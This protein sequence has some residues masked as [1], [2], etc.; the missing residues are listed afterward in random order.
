MNLT[1]HGKLKDT[2]KTKFHFEIGILG[3]QQSEG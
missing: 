3:I 1:F 2:K